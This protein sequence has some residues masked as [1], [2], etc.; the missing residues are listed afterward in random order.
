MVGGRWQ[1]D[2]GGP[3]MMLDD[4]GRAREIARRYNREY[5]DLSSFC[6]LKE[7]LKTV[8]VE[9]MFRY[10]VIPLEE[11]RHGKLAIAIADPSQLMMI[12][13]I[14]LVLNRKIETRVSTLLQISRTLRRTE[15]T[16]GGKQA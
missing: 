10:N 12:D 11:T 5:V 14:A 1:A 7:L 4:E 9:L 13:E 6:I 16:Q 2:N 8:P 15:E 3:A